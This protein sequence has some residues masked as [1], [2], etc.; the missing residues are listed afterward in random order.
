M[1]KNYGKR[2]KGLRAAAFAMAA[3][4]AVTGCGGG[5]TSSS[6]KTESKTTSSAATKSTPETSSGMS[7]QTGSETSESSSA[8]ES[9]PAATG[10]AANIAELL[11]VQPSADGQMAKTVYANAENVLDDKYRTTYEI[12]PYS[13]RDSDGDGI[14][15]LKGIIEAL[16]YLNDGNPETNTDLGVNGLWLTPV[17]P[18]Q[19][20]H[21]YDV[22]DYCAI[23]PTF[24]TMEDYEKLLDGCHKRG[25]RVYLDL[26]L[27]HTSDTHPWFTAAAEYLK[28]LPEGEEPDLEAC[29]YVGYYNF[30]RQSDSGYAKLAGTDWYYEARFWDEM[31]DLNLDNEDVRKE[32]TDIA[33]FWLD[34]G[35]DGFR[36]DAVL[37]Y[38]TNSSD[39]NIQFLK[40]FNDTVKGINPNAYIVGECWA[41]KNQ[42]AEYYQSGIDSLFDFAFAQN[43]GAIAKFL[44]GAF[45]ADVVAKGLAD[46][47]AQFAENGEAYVNAPFFTNHDTARGAGY[48]AGDDG[49]KMKMAEALNLLTTGNAFLYYG[50]ELGMRGSG[51]DENKRAPMFWSAEYLDCLCDGPAAMDDFEM[52]YASLE[53]QTADENSILSFVRALI[54]VRNS[55]PAIARGK[56][57]PANGICKDKLLAFVKTLDGSNAK[58]VDAQGGVY[59]TTGTASKDEV[60]ENVVDVLEGGEEVLVF[61]NT[62]ENDANVDLTA[63]EEAA[64]FRTIGAVLTARDGEVTLDGDSLTLPGYSVA[65]LTK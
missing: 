19:T 24:G 27:N 12:F 41:G 31:P 25:I 13:F 36:L 14:G 10:K 9:R 65:I 17:H 40:W 56:V 38:Y 11:S 16:D 7:S 45:T 8:A 29:P 33:K 55:Y 32:I 52:K 60:E 22:D 34:K 62:D 64:G 59:D 63:S 21:K 3:M 26:V 15:D 44:N 49:S 58:L 35:V 28:K 46:E 6:T 51:K 1:T 48:F 43:D 57:V 20:Y 5:G 42:Y 47:Q 61:L 39:R 30:S 23:D 54:H 2:K 53:E 4:L 37:F 18:S 50:E